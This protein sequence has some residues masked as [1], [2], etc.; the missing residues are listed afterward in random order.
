MTT[1]QQF[2]LTQAAREG[3][4]D[5]LLQIINSDPSATKFTALFEAI[6]HGHSECVDALLDHMNEDDRQDVHTEGGLL[7][8]V[9]VEFKHWHFFHKVFPLVGPDEMETSLL[10]SVVRSGNLECFLAVEPY[11]PEQWEAGVVLAVQSKNIAALERLA[12][13]YGLEFGRAFLEAIDR[14]EQCP[15][16]VDVLIPHAS[17]G[18]LNRGLCHAIT[19]QGSLI[20][21]LLT[22]CHPKDHDNEAFKNALAYG[23]FD[24]AAQ[25]APLS[26]PQQVLMELLEDNTDADAH[27]I[28]WLEEW[29]AQDLNQRLRT[30]VDEQR[31]PANKTQRKM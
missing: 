24:M 23:H 3:R 30:H 1:T 22:L 8:Y 25:M 17:P 14:F 31:E 5:N 9:A 11:L 27:I 15:Q 26:D 19:R 10:S 28:A 2:M 4:C 13:K 16:M 29:I 12:P 18:L 6:K 7:L 20:P 21:K